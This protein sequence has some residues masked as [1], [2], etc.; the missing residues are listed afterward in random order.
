MILL[1]MTG[2][3]SHLFKSSFGIPIKANE[4]EE[5]VRNWRCIPCNHPSN[6]VIDFQL[7]TSMR[8]HRVHSMS[9][10]KR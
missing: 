5:V 2:K 9:S 8:I 7:P 6:N 4:V 1:N 3:K 10:S